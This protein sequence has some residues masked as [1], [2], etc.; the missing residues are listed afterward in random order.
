MHISVRVI[1]AIAAFCSP[2]AFAGSADAFVMPVERVD[3]TVFPHR[4]ENVQVVALRIEA[5]PTPSGSVGGVAGYEW[6]LD[7]EV[8]LRNLEDTDRS[9]SLAWFVSEDSR[10]R[11]SYFVGGSPAG[12]RVTTIRR[13]PARS[14]IR[15]GAYPVSEVDLPAR[16][17]VPLRLR[18]FVEAT[19]DNLG[20]TTFSIPAEIFQ[21]YEGSIG[22]TVISLILPERPIGLVA[23]LQSYV[24][25]DE[26]ENRLSWFSIDWA[27]EQN[28]DIAWLGAWP[29]LLLVAEVEECPQP[30][31]VVQGM[32]SGHVSAVN[33]YL[34]GF[35]EQTLD[36]CK[37]LPLVTHGFVFRSEMVRER[38][39]ELSVNRY[40]GGRTDRGSL[41][42]ENPAF[43]EEDLTEPERVYRRALSQNGESRQ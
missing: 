38:L 23:S 5:R 8:W 29:A 42:R 9:V 19:R 16:T 15:G 13:D 1:I 31:R 10:P 14:S 6:E 20:Q 35:D 33:N 40:V 4:V 24:F 28:L 25:Y 26:P 17:I 30:W 41:Y 18:T 32:M 2:L 37:S 39:T 21:L 3:D 11:S 7:V 34:D 27:P 22:S 36:F 12:A 43:N